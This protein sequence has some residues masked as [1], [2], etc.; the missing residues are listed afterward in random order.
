MK[1]KKNIMKSLIIIFVLIIVIPPISLNAQRLGELA[2]EK[3]LEVF[4]EHAWGMDI[5]FG[6]AGFGLGTF[7][8]KQLSTKWT[9]FIDIS[10]SEGKD[11]REF[12][13]IDIFGNK[14]VAGKKNRLFQVPLNVGLQYRLFEN[15]IFD[16]LRPYLNAGV[17]PTLVL[18]TPFDQEF[19]NAFGDATTKF[20]F[21][22][23]VGFGANFGLDKS[24]L[25]GLNFRYY[26]SYFFNDGVEILEGKKKK[27]ISGFFI[28]LNLGIMY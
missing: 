10:L 3:P 5:M 1:N 24:S 26:N 18:L 6:D 8:R 15:D 12:E 17:G 11:E 20:A 16:N 25:I 2:P 19:F 23:Y 27:N 4:P 28:T 7:L 9:A 13:F 22:G 14:F 21:G